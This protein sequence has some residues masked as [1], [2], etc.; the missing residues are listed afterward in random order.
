MTSPVSHD[1]QAVAV[2][3]RDAGLARRTRRP[4]V[5]CGRWLTRRPRGRGKLSMRPARLGRARP[6]AAAAGR[7]AGRARGRRR[8]SRARSRDDVEGRRGV[9]LSVSCRPPARRQPSV[10]VHRRRRGPGPRRWP[11][12]ARHS[13]LGE[14]DSTNPAGRPR[15]RHGTPAPASALSDKAVATSSTARGGASGVVVKTSVHR[16][17]PATR[18]ARRDGDVV[19]ASVPT[20]RVQRPRHGCRRRVLRVAAKAPHQV[21]IPALCCA[22]TSGSFSSV[23]RHHATQMSKLLWTFAKH[24]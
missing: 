21:F 16:P 3:A 22:R 12:T 20:P 17:P 24:C 2:A 8:Q 11:C 23:K 19:T 15:P 10:G 5:G 13:R 9:V 1:Q 14:G 18:S 6:R 4:P 7:S